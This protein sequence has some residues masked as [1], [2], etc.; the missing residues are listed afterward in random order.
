MVFTINIETRVPAVLQLRHAI[1]GG[2][3]SVTHSLCLI[4]VCLRD[5]RS[6]A[7]RE[8]ILVLNLSSRLF[9]RGESRQS[10]RSKLVP[11]SPVL[12]WSRICRLCISKEMARVSI[13]FTG[14]PY[15]FSW[16]GAGSSISDVSNWKRGMTS[17]PKSI[18]V[19]MRPPVTGAK[20]DPLQYLHSTKT[21]L[22]WHFKV[23]IY[24]LE[25]NLQYGKNLLTHE[26]VCRELWI[27]FETADWL[28][29]NCMSEAEAILHA[30]FCVVCFRDGSARSK[31]YSIC[32]C[33][34]NSAFTIES[35]T[36]AIAAENIG[37]CK[38]VC[39]K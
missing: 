20:T 37:E 16:K 22:I 29:W 3:N 35:Y 39:S 19:T 24:Y 17:F 21:K 31:R 27:F 36:R 5:S 6:E 34:G 18:G 7:E 13:F 26:S 33:R 32:K 30:K 15:L 23:Q 9:R 10:R 25:Y 4:I 28:A 8:R 11:N 14:C 12:F 2:T 38:I 1:A